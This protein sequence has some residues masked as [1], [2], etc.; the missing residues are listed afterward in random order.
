[1]KLREM[2]NTEQ[3]LKVRKVKDDLGALHNKID[4][5]MSAY[6]DGQYHIGASMVNKLMY[7]VQQVNEKAQKLAVVVTEQ[8]RKHYHGELNPQN[9]SQPE[10]PN[11]DKSR[12]FGYFEEVKE[13]EVKKREEDDIPF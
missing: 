2:L 8:A 1:M 13:V 7:D 3:V 4:H 12:A 11:G 9:Q 6:Q 10:E 5:V